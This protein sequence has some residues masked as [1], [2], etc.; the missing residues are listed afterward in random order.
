VAGARHRLIAPRAPLTAPVAPTIEA[1]GDVDVT[2]TRMR[3]SIRAAVERYVIRGGREGYDRLLLLARDRRPDTAALLQRAGAGPGMRCA[4]LG[5]GGGEVTLELAALVGASGSAT[6]VDMDGLKLD[7]ARAAAARRGIAN[8]E[9]VELNVNEWNETAAYDLVFSR[10]V[11]QHLRHPVDMLQ[12]MWAAVRPG[13]VIVVEDAD[14]DGWCCHPFNDG[15][16]FFL[17][18]YGQVLARSGGDHTFGRKLYAGFIEAG[19]PAP[20][21]RLVQPVYR[22]GDAKWLPWTTL[23]ASGDAIVAE[24]VAS[25]EEVQTAL[26]S[27]SAFTEDASTLISGPRIFQAWARR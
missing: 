27:L 19:I 11:L 3:S 2:S 5:C 15:F 7:L 1:V 13:G 26:A 10:F 23:D 24:G 25:A 8:A 22:E 20:D 9:F 21:V 18:T 16:E 6:G 12:R 14:F 17:R 4:D